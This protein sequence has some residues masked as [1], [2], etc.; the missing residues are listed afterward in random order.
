MK[1]YYSINLALFFVLICFAACNTE[2][3]SCKAPVGV[4][5]IHWGGVANGVSCGMRLGKTIHHLGETVEISV[6]LKS[7]RAEDVVVYCG[8]ISTGKTLDNGISEIYL[9]V[10]PSVTDGTPQERKRIL[11]SGEMTKVAT[12]RIPTRPIDS[13]IADLHFTPKKWQVRV[14][15]FSIPNPEDFSSID[16]RAYSDASEVVVLEKSK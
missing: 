9:R 10:E 14:A 4:Q 1:K 15:C 8:W 16:F 11:R 3:Y 7:T 2:R 12:A 6:F 13:G 5:E